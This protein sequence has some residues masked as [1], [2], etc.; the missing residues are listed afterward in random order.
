[1]KDY[2]AAKYSNVKFLVEEESTTNLLSHEARWA[3]DLVRQTLMI[4][5]IRPAI[6][7]TPAAA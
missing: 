2:H 3:Y 1:V 6:A 4:P 7:A 5:R